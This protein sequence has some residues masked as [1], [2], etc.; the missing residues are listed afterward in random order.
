MAS[1]SEAVHYRVVVYN[2]IRILIGLEWVDTYCV[3]IEMVVSQYVLVNAERYD[4][5]APSVICVE[6]GDQF[7]SNVHFV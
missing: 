4:G 3:G 5:G 6:L 1:R 7:V 2:A